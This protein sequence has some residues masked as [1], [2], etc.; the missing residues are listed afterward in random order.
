MLD[1]SFVCFITHYKAMKR[2]KTPRAVIHPSKGKEQGKHSILYIEL[3]IIVS[4][5]VRYWEVGKQIHDCS[6]LSQCPCSACGLLQIELDVLN[7]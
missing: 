5:C 6:R 2:T 3:L 1:T 4:I 7:L